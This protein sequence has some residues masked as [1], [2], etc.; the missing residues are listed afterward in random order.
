MAQAEI[1]WELSLWDRSTVLGRLNL[2]LA[3]QSRPIA[4]HP[5]SGFPPRQPSVHPLFT[6]Q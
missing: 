6:C 5:A 3:P 4:S 2:V 1:C